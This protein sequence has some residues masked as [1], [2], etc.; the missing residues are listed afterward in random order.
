MPSLVLFGHGASEGEASSAPVR[1]HAAA[2]VRMGIFDQVQVGFWKEAP[3]W[4]EAVGPVSV[5]P[6]AVVPFFM[7]DGYFVREVLPRELARGGRA[8]S[9]SAPVGTDARLGAVIEALAL[10]AIGGE[11]AAGD[12]ALALVGHGTSR[13]GSSRRAA[14]EHAARLGERGVFAQV[15]AVFTDD[16]P[17]VEEALSLCEGREVVAVPFMSAEGYH[18]RETIPASLGWAGSGGREVPFRVG[19]RRVWL[20]GALGGTP[21]VSS[22]ILSRAAEALGGPLP[23]SGSV[24]TQALW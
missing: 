10:E 13:S 23:A 19:G 1:A 15:V 2:I 12:V 11:A 22:V 16:A 7:S 14:L 8:A 3:R 17:R 4:H 5:E 18:T 21:H 24:I 6:I 20:A 9:V